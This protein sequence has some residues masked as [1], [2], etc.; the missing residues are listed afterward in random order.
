MILSVE[1]HGH[2]VPCL[3]AEKE[4]FKSANENS[5]ELGRNCPQVTLY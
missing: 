3:I 1:K 4:S 2:Q 5:K